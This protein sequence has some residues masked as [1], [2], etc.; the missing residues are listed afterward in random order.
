MCSASTSRNSPCPSTQATGIAIRCSALGLLGAMLLVPAPAR[1]VDGCRALLCLAAPDWR[2]I[3][4]CVPTIRQLMRD[5]AKGRPFPTC[6]MAGAGNHA[7]HDWAIAPAFCPVQYTQVIETEGGHRTRCDYLGAFTVEIDGAPWSRIWW[8][9]EGGSV[10]EFFPA[11]RQRLGA[12][13]TRFDD[14]L[15]RW[16]SMQP[17][18]SAAS[19]N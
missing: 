6:Q 9:M 7:R 16:L 11:A 10:T 3:P 15:A 2:A 8:R 18:A 1:A 19:L 12:W 13:D 14:D 4:E 5:L 17:Q